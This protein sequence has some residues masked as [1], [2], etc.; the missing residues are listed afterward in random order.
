VLRDQ[1]GGAGQSG[2][3]AGGLPPGY[4]G[5][6]AIWRDVPEERVAERL[7]AGAPYTIRFRSA[8]P[9][10]QRVSFTDDIRGQLAMDDNRND[11]VILKASD[12]RPRL[13][14]YHFAH[15][16]DDHLMRVT[17]VIRGEE[18][19][20][21]VPLHL[22]LFQALGFDQVRYAHIAPLMKQ[23]GGS[24]RKLSKRH[25]PEASVNFYIEQGYPARAV[26]YY[27]RG[28]ANG[29]LAEMPLEQALAEPIRLA[30][31]GT[32]GPLLDLVKLDDIC[33]DRVATLSGGQ[34]L[35]E[36]AAWARRY[37]PE[38]AA[39]LESEPDLALRA[40]A[41]EREGVANPRKD[42]RKWADFRPVYG[43]F[44]SGLFRPVTDPADPRFGSLDPD[45]V[46]AVAAA[47]ADRYRPDGDDWF[48]QIR[49]AAVSLGFAPSRKVYRQDPASYPGSIVEAS[50]VVRVLLTGTRDSP[51]LA[52]VAIALGPDEVLRRI[53]ALG[54]QRETGTMAP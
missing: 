14:T 23:A 20:S 10:A 43:Y 46:G 49:R 27:L 36:A 51:G 42:V 16:V 32:A 1:A 35:D 4:Y 18:W 26:E 37:D 31:L 50:Q 11:A 33:A 45:L 34:L 44:F 2:Q 3:A 13:P 28:L 54:G 29:R 22:Q 15:A 24:R 39:V 8:G 38:L 7:A 53:Y 17:L 19:I 21:S 52:P 9:A 48:D 47:I 12:T 25:D 5:Q 6:W 41:I 40:L 30:E